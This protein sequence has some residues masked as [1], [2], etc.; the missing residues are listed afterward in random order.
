MPPG[1]SR[2]R[3]R[4]NVYALP[5]LPSKKN[6]LSNPALLAPVII[7]MIIIMLIILM[8]LIIITT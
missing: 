5:C 7:I 2:G 1:C 4:T 6:P 3:L 8:I